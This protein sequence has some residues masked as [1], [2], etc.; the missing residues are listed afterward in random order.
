[1]ANHTLSGATGFLVGETTY[2][3]FT[4]D[5]GDANRKGVFWTPLFTRDYGVAAALATTNIVSGSSVTTAGSISMNGSLVSGGVAD[6]TIPRT[7]HITSTSDLSAIQMT[8]TGTREY[9]VPQTETI[10]LPNVTSVETQKTFL[11]VSG[12]SIDSAHGTAT[13]LV[14]VGIDNAFGLPY[15]ASSLSSIVA[16]TVSGRSATTLTFTAA[17]AATGVATATTADTC[18]KVKFG[19]VPDAAGTYSITVVVPLSK[20]VTKVFGATPA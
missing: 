8:I 11:T 17:F 6:L 16:C 4:N 2:G 10:L 18:G 7:L 3:Y 15:Y 14:N 1:M 9:G 19:L 13:T 20:D 12:I 5:I